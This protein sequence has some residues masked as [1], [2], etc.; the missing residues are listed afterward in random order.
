MAEQ[1]YAEARG[2]G[3]VAGAMLAFAVI[4]AL[5]FIY[6][7]LTTGPA[8]APGSATTAPATE[9]AAPAEPAPAE[10]AAAAPASN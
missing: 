1:T 10:P 9:V 3:L 8:P 6:T 5:V 4:V 7:G 2:V